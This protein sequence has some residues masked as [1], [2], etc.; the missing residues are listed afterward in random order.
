MVLKVLN[1]PLA[2]QG[3]QVVRGP[4]VR[5]GANP[6]PGGFKLGGY[7]GLDA[8]QAV[9]TAYTG[10]TASVA[11]VGTNQVRLAPHPNVSWE[12][13][14]P[15][16]GPEYLAPGC[17]VHLG[18]I[19]RGATIEFVEC[20][21]LG[22]WQEGRLASEG[23]DVAQGNVAAGSALASSA[24]QR[25]P[26]AYDA[27]RV[28]RIRTSYAPFWFMGCTFL[29][30]LTTAGTIGV[31]GLWWYAARDVASLGPV[32]E[33]YE[34]YESVDLD[35]TQVDLG[36]LE[37]LEKPY[38]SFVM[39]PNIR[40]ADAGGKGWEEP[41]RW[42]PRFLQYTTASVEQHV[43]SWAFFS[44]LE[45]VRV[46]YAKVVLAMRKAG[47]PEVFA[48][49]P[50]QESRYN[51]SITSEV[52]A[53]GYWQ[54]MPEGGY[55]MADKGMRV[56]ECSFRGSAGSSWTPTDPAPPPR[57]RET[58]AYMDEGQ[59]M[60]ERCLVDE[61]KDLEKST[62]AAIFTL[63]E[64]WND[65]LIAQSGSAVQLTITSHNAGYDDSRFGPKYTKR[66]NVKP[67]FKAFVD[68]NGSDQGMFF[69]GQNIRC[70]TSTERSTCDASYMAESQHYAYTIVAQHVLAV[71]YYAKN[72]GEDPAFTPWRVHTASDGYCGQFAIPT[73]EEV[74]ARRTKRVGT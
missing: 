63:S 46:E 64:A 65:A 49:I 45:A 70:R 12:D 7:R 58:G 73:K 5:L 47:L 18:P 36:L 48:A 71:C 34:F 30:A 16:P 19:G 13:I 37:G 17:A 60:I 24:A 15:I 9:I 25:L 72:Y 32:D 35:V 74:R 56:A 41:E 50:Y 42:D 43:K 68:K 53:E 62:A 38:Y 66:F 31:A 2:A 33:G 52:C 22:L 14:D 55:R 51:A 40:A 21:R 1:G 27:R 8:R 26:A 6:G 59:C 61:R 10:G 23:T 4:V 57:V 28:G 11:P 67:A 39:E 44:R 54:F 3:E 20:R 69:T 29:M